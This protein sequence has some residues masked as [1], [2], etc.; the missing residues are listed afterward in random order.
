MVTKPVWLTVLAVAALLGGCKTLDK[1]KP[2]PVIPEIE[3]QLSSAGAGQTAGRDFEV[4][5]A[6]MDDI[7]TGQ[8]RGDIL[9]SQEPHFHVAADGVA[10]RP[11]F[12]SLVADTPYSVIV[13]PGVT[14]SISLDLKDVTL[15]ETIE[16]VKD[17]YG[18]DIRR[19]GK[20]ITVRAPGLRTETLSVN[21]LMMTRNGTSSVTIN[22]GGV[23][24]N[25]N[26][27]GG[28]GGNVGGQSGGNQLSGGG[29]QLG[30]GAGNQV[31][32]GG[33]GQQVSG[34]NIQTSS[35]SDFWKDLKESLE[36]L[37]G[38]NQGRTVIVSPMTGLVTI[39][40]F[41]EE[42]RAVRE[43]LQMSEQTLRRQVILEAKIV[44]VSLSDD[45]QQG[46]DW[47]EALGHIG[48]TDFSFSNNGFS[49]PNNSFANTISAALGGGNQHSLS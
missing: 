4:P 15:D 34:T 28:G 8:N 10:V 19:Q 26:N 27:G 48:S 16:A 30:G 47:G 18:F 21:Y 45:Y 11:F 37:V 44:E 46:I 36:A 33:F 6:V 7:L 2:R 3:Q 49:T 12:A 29:N 22:A 13:H 23:S 24:Q 42:I 25:G 43:F 31:G 38:S 5:D 17:T 20:I 14:G 40:A 32:G 9:S 39:R 35:E 1:P 41:P